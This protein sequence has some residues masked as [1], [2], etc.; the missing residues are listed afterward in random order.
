MKDECRDI[1]AFLD[2]Y[3]EARLAPEAVRV[4]EEHIAE[5]PD[6]DA[7]LAS[8]R[9]T[10]AVAG[11]ALGGSAAP[12]TEPTKPAPDRLIEAIL[13]ARRRRN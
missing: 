7:F 6:C 1:T 10:R 11:E 13:A 9:A 5:C 12:S 4:F 3:L 2:E 8:Y